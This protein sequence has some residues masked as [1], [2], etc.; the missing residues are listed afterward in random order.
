MA[1]LI[2]LP[3]VNHRW[4]LKKTLCIRE[5]VTK[6]LSIHDDILKHLAVKLYF[7]TSSQQRNKW[8]GGSRSKMMPSEKPLHSLELL[9]Q[10]RVSNLQQLYFALSYFHD[11]ISNF[12]LMIHLLT[13]YEI[14]LHTKNTISF[15]AFVFLIGSTQM[16]F[17]LVGS[18][19][20][21]L[22]P[23]FGFPRETIAHT[24]SIILFRR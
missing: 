11:L 20:I 12:F 2:I 22:L 14:F 10:N 5:L 15:M 23:Y 24:I 6:P 16:M 18:L 21:V 19:K 3:L 7:V 17:R 4:A 13:N 9:I 8:V 1:S